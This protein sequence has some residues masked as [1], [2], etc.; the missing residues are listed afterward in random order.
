MGYSKLLGSYFPERQDISD[1]TKNS[2]F[3]RWLQ[4]M[5]YKPRIPTVYQK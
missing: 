2:L 3:M 4:T 5:Y 1:N